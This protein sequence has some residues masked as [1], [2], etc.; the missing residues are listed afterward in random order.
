MSL[1]DYFGAESHL[2]S[3]GVKDKYISAILDVTKIS[4]FKELKTARDYVDNEK[5]LNAIDYLEK[6]YS[7][8]K[9][10]GFEEYVSVDLGML[11]KVNYYTGMV[12][13]RYTYGTGDAIV[14]GGRYDS[15]LGN[16]GKPTNA[17][18]AVFLVDDL[19]TALSSQNLL[20][21]IS[22][23]NI[24]VVYSEHDFDVEEAYDI[25]KA[26]LIKYKDKN[27]MILSEYDK[28]WEDIYLG[29]DLLEFIDNNGFF[30]IS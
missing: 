13:N 18:G 5:S 17:V 27:V 14:K 16:F 19:M 21:E 8:I 26:I 25:E 23:K 15:L 11:S 7:V 29:K 1:K 10:Y 20:P 2:R 22:P 24:W 4:S 6:V 3:I 30:S 28:S 9:M 12:F